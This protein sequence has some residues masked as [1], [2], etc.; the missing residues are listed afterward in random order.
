MSQQEIEEKV[1]A[2]LTKVRR[3]PA[4]NPA[5]DTRFEELKL[6]SLD[7]MCA[8]FDLEEAFNIS[9]PDDAAQNMR[10]IRD[11]VNNIVAVLPSGP[12]IPAVREPRAS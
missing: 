9:I 3:D 11:V 6:E 5:L 10:C 7:V 8:V 2:I 1:L 4:V 12:S